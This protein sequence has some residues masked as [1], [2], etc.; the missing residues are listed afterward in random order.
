[1][2]VRSGSALMVSIPGGWREI[3]QGLEASPEAVLRPDGT[4]GLYT[5]IGGRVHRLG[6]TWEPLGEGSFIDT[7]SALP[8][9]MV[10]ARRAYGD[11][12][13]VG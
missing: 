11:V 7:V 1:V 10:Y 2:Y 13:R 4:V 3:A 5:L 12:L 8:D 6:T 9:G